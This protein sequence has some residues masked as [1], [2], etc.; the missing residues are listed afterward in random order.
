MVGHETWQKDPS[1]GF[2]E[3]SRCVTDSFGRFTLEGLDSGKYHVLAFHPVH[4]PISLDAEAGEQNLKFSLVVPA[5]EKA[6]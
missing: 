6:P 4:P 3:E 1:T 2:L 5:P